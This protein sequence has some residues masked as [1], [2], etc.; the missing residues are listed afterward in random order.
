M[1]DLIRDPRL[2]N[3]IEVISGVLADESAELLKDF[4][5][6]KALSTY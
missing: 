2:P 4:F 3:K 1:W 5:I 6:K